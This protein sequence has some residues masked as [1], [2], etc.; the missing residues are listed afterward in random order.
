AGWYPITV[1]V[2]NASGTVVGRA[3]TKAS[4]APA[5]PT[6]VAN[7]TQIQST[8]ATSFSGT[9]ATFT[10]ARASAAAG[11]FTATI[12]WGDGSTSTG[13]AECHGERPEYP[14]DQR[15][16]VLGRRRHVHRRQHQRGGRRFQS[17]H[18]LGRRDYLRR[19]HHCQFQGRL[20]SHG[21]AH[22]H[23]HPEWPRPG[24]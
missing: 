2:D 21:H 24:P 3:L 9:V 22:L 13:T 14:C 5:P 4:V 18:R 11:D 19:H 23:Q 8:A 12:D 10:D 17:H 6:V 16:G 7:G 20:R 1:T 15:P